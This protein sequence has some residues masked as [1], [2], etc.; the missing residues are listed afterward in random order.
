MFMIDLYPNNQERFGIDMKAIREAIMKTRKVD[1]PI[2][3]PP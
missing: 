2:G 3:N 1:S